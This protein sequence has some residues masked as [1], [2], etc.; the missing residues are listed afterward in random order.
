MQA[1]VT[2]ATGYLG[3][4]VVRLLCADGAAVRC[5]VRP[6]S[7]I[8]ELR[9]FVGPRHWAQIEIVRGSLLR[10]D[11]LARALEH[12]DVV[13]HVAAALKGS[14]SSLFL[15]TVVPTRRLVEA[16]C[17]QGV[18]RFVHV[19]S[20]AVYGTALLASGATVGETTPI[21][22]SAHLRDAYTYSK[23]RQEEVCWEAHRVQGLP[24]VVIRPGVIF[25]P[26]RG[27]LSSRI[28]LKLG[29]W[30]LAMGTD[31]SLPYTFVD[32]CAHAVR[33]AGFVAGVEGHAFNVIDDDLPTAREA[34]R[35]HRD[36]GNRLRTL[37]IPRPLIDPLCGLYE[38]YAR[39]SRGQLPPVLTR[40]R[41]R[42]LWKKL[43]Y[44]NGKAK[45]LLRW[46]PPVPMREAIE[47]SLESVVASVPRCRGEQT[48]SS[49]LAKSSPDGTS[50]SS[51]A[52]TFAERK[53]TMG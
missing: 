15:N 29:G 25:G 4:R 52:A 21:D 12:V 42:S 28:G 44:S 49:Q 26:G 11:D 46:M 53:A 24:L 33:Q 50:T 1:L 13:F 27:I 43:N 19:S 18:S 9:S 41:S 22:Q 51:T 10:D 30:M 39:F 35:C 7:D 31:Q 5:L 34:L 45:S 32:N 17:K 40:Y 20:L 23:I 37:R 38:W 6:T 36:R 14:A 3:R 16:A 48:V 2:G 8:E 47:Q